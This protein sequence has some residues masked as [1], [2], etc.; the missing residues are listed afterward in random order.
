VITTRSGLNLPMVAVPP[1]PHTLFVVVHQRDHQGGSAQDYGF[2]LHVALQSAAQVT[3]QATPH[4]STETAQVIPSGLTVVSGELTGVD[5]QDVYSISGNSLL[6]ASLHTDADLEMEAEC[7]G[8]AAG[9]HS[10]NRPYDRSAHFLRPGGSVINCFVS[11][12]ARPGDIGRP[13]G[14]YRLI[15]D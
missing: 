8:G 6:S 4:D 1:G 14:L 9:N 2:E 15:I 11:V 10:T 13:T 5:G 3:E 12:R 7:A